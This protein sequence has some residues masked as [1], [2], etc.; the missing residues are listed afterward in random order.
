MGV[1]HGGEVD[2]GL[3]AALQVRLERCLLEGFEIQMK[4]YSLHSH[5]GPPYRSHV[6]PVGFLA[7]GWGGVRDDPDVAYRRR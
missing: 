1:E 4:P 3:P 6:E 7:S 5:K 2:S